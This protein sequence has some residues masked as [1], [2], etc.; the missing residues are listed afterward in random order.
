MS[1]GE[2][3]VK[4]FSLG[5]DKGYDRIPSKIFLTPK[6]RKQRKREQQQQ[7]GQQGPA[8]QQYNQQAQPQQGQ[9]YGQG[10]GYQQDPYAQQ[11][12]YTRGYQDALNEG[13]VPDNQPAIDDQPYWNQQNTRGDRGSSM[14]DGSYPQQQA[15]A[16]RGY[17]PQDYQ[18][19]GYDDGYG[20][21]GGYGGDQYGVSAHFLLSH[22][23]YVMA[24]VARN[25]QRG[26]QDKR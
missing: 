26:L 10:S 20:G 19:R 2:I 8:G 9:A 11:D 22:R 25:A 18:P 16:R 1:G 6:E 24:L 3:G 23:F 21:G 4:A 14:Q 15:G 5:I 13:Y 12:P 7:Q 17:N